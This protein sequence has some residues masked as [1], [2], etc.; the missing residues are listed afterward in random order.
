MEH[1]ELINKPAK[2]TFVAMLD[3]TC[4]RCHKGKL[5][6]Y[7][8][9]SAKFH[10]MNSSCPVCH[11]DL[12]IEPGFYYGAMYFSYALTVAVEAVIIVI[13]HLLFNDPELWVY[14]VAISFTLI[15]ISPAVFRYSRVMMLYFFGSVKYDPNAARQS[16]ENQQ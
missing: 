3:G 12:E 8:V 14:I 6:P 16:F 9:L 10:K 11:Q 15:L 4:P 5:F 7:P 2:S 1:T 13:M